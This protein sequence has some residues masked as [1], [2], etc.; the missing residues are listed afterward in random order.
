MSLFLLRLY[1]KIKSFF[2]RKNDEEYILLI[3]FNNLG[4]LVCDTPSLRNI[5]REYKSA[6]IIMLVRNQSCIEFMKL[7]PYIDEVIEMPHSKDSLKEY[8]RFAE[9]LRKYN[10]IFSLQFVRPFMEIKRTY[11]PYILNIKSRY[12]LLQKPYKKYY[13]F[14]FTDF[15]LLNNTTTR[16]EE[17]L[18]LVRLLHIEIDNENTECWIDENSVSAEDF[19]QYIIIQTCAT[20]KCRMWHQSNFVRLID[21]ILKTYNIKIL[22]TGT[23]NEFN[24]INKIRDLCIEKENIVALCDINISTLLYYLKHAKF[25]ITN[26]T[27]PFHFARAFNVPTIVLFGISPPEYLI[28]NK[29]NSCI[30]LRGAI[31]CS[32][33]CYIGKMT[34]YSCKKVYKIFGDTCHCINN[35]AV[36]DV[37]NEVNKLMDE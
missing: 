11:L 4:D 19:G 34:N 20:M 3:N 33:N 2:L 10:F 7:C 17:S 13:K 30:A 31:E 29:L 6:R 26:D 5:R 8:A 37:F 32:E 25:L 36:N 9:S 28:R 1:F 18:S 16:T 24:Y 22:L 27:G 12:G 15:I 14:A 21:N 35:I 23:K